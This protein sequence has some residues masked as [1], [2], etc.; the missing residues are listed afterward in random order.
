[1]CSKSGQRGAC[2]KPGM[3]QKVQL[4][5]QPSPTRRYAECLGVSRCRSPSSLNPI[6]A[7]PTCTGQN[8]PFCVTLLLYTAGMG[9]AR[10]TIKVW[11]SF[12]PCLSVAPAHASP[13]YQSALAAV[14]QQCSLIHR[15]PFTVMQPQQQAPTFHQHSLEGGGKCCEGYCGRSAAAT[16]PGPCCWALLPAAR[17]PAPPAACSAGC[18]SSQSPQ[19]GPPPAGSLHALFLLRLV[20]STS[21]ETSSNVMMGQKEECTMQYLPGPASS[22]APGSL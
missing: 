15:L 18:C 1:M 22:A 20:L 2:L 14:S 6:V 10:Y 16:V 5:E 17:R 3:A 12:V 19:S 8:A 9:P 13:S 4:W 11:R 21:E 7:C